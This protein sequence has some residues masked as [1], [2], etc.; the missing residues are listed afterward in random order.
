VYLYLYLLFYI[1]EGLLS[2]LNGQYGEIISK[3]IE[4]LTYVATFIFFAMLVPLAGV[5]SYLATVAVYG[6]NIPT[7]IMLS[8]GTDIIENKNCN[9]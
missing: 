1:D 8:S 7:S 6:E 4:K 3:E 9:M 5:F 2:L